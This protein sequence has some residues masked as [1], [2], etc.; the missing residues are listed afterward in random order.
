MRTELHD[1]E[2]ASAQS[3]GGRKKSDALF[4]SLLAFCILVAAAF[5][6]F[7]NNRF[8]VRCHID[9]PGKVAQIQSQERNFHHPLLLLNTTQGVCALFRV[10]PTAQQ[11]VWMGR[12]C[13]AVF[14][15]LALLA[16]AYGA[17]LVAGR[18]A[19]L[20]CAFF[21]LAAPL[22]IELSHYFKEDPAFMM[23]IAFAFLAMILYQR[24]PGMRP[25]LFLAASAALACSGKHIGVLILPFCLYTILKNGG[26]RN[27]ALLFGGVTLLGYAL[28][29]YQVF[30]HLGDL[31]GAVGQETYFL[32]KGGAKVVAPPPA[33]HSL[34]KYLEVLS[35]NIPLPFIWFS[36]FCVYSWAKRRESAPLGPVF[37]FAGILF[38]GLSM[39]P[40]TA[41]RYLMPV[42][43]LLGFTS[44]IGAARILSKPG[45]VWKIAG[46]ALPLAL[47]VV[48]EGKEGWRAFESF[49]KDSRLE[50]AHWIA[51]NLPPDALIAQDA[52]G[53]LVSSASAGVSDD[54]Y[55][56]PQRLMDAGELVRLRS[57][58]ALRSSGAQYL[59]VI[60]DDYR[61]AA[62]KKHAPDPDS[63]GE[64]AVSR[65]LETQCRQVWAYRDKSRRTRTVSPNLAIYQLPGN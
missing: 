6:F 13:S 11:I 24:R 47:A 27:H 26:G 21:L 49:G 54:P 48:S 39:T 28:V 42:I 43:G 64:L 25:L 8:S 46:F 3:K 32:K 4:L 29:N 56:V 2:V 62:V 35:K 30:A 23:G 36:G 9:E 51:R 61:P 55:Q 14:S 5:L 15:T 52:R 1:P 20:L 31:V 57:L 37:L 58:D 65:E 63:G 40:K 7:T 38:A 18:A 53:F 17:F 41:E 60:S 50:M 45:W 59:V 44:A 34:Q 22:F 33:L 12:T 16:L 10:E 19:A